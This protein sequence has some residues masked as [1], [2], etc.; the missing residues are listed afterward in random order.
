MVSAG[1]LLIVRVMPRSR[2]E[3]AVVGCSAWLRFDE[4][5]GC[6]IVCCSEGEPIWL[7]RLYCSLLVGTAFLNVYGGI[8]FSGETD[9]VCCLGKRYERGFGILFERFSLYRR[10]NASR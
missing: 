3:E 9:R 4:D 6:A 1:Q 5:V 7:L 8:S 2:Y 10:N